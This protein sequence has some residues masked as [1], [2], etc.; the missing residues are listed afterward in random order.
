MKERDLASSV[1]KPLTNTLKQDFKSYE[2][3]R[4]LNAA[5]RVSGLAIVKLH[6]YYKG[7]T[8]LTFHTS[9]GDFKTV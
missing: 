1:T 2:I 6:M 4:G 8:Q 9:V 5:Q 3:C 7:T